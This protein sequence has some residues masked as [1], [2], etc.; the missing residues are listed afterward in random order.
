ML[1]FNKIHTHMTVFSHLR[2]NKHTKR[3]LSDIIDSITHIDN[4]VEIH[5]I[6]GDYDFIIKM[7]VRDMEHYSQTIFSISEKHAEVM[8]FKSEFVLK[9]HKEIA[10]M[11]VSYFTDG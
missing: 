7:I 10:Q 5:N 9:K 6:S 1:D 3:V 8:G 11:P 2:L 4:I